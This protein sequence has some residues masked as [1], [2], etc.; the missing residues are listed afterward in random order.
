LKSIP[1]YKTSLDPDAR[2]ISNRFRISVAFGLS[3]DEVNQWSIQ[4]NISILDHRALR[5]G[6]IDVEIPQAVLMR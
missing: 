2:S 4:N 6:M 5:Y 3:I 1:E